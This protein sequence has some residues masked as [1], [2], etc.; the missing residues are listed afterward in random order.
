[1]LLLR[2]SYFVFKV[3]IVSMSAFRQKTY[4]RT[5]GPYR[6]TPKALENTSFNFF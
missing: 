3:L 4:L 2:I 1:M 5:H 6:K